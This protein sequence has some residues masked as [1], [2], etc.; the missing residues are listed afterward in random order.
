MT[1]DR[2]AGN[3]MQT[4]FL[5]ALP[6]WLADA[7]P[8]YLPERR[9]FGDKARRIHAV[10][11]S[12]VVPIN[13]VD[14]PSALAFIDVRF[15]SG[16]PSQY[17]L[18][19][20]HTLRLP[21]DSESVISILDDGYLV[22]GLTESSVR[23]RLLST[24]G[25]NV[26][27][28]AKSLLAD[29]DA[30]ATGTLSELQGAESRLLRAEQSNTSILYGSD[31]L[32]KVFRRLQPGINP[33]VELT[34]FLSSR[35]GFDAVPRYLGSIS[36]RTTAGTTSVI[37]CA[38]EFV[39]NVGD[40]WSFVLKKIRDHLLDPGASELLSESA[41]LARQLGIVSARMHLALASDS[42]TPGLA[43]EPIRRSDAE[44]WASDYLGLIDRVVTGLNDQF[45]SFDPETRELATLFL[46]GAPGLQ[47]R[48]DGFYGLIG[49]SKTRVHG[50]YHLGQTLRTLDGSF[51][52][53]DFEG[54]PQRS[55]EERCRKTSPLKDIAGMLR[56]FSYARGTATAWLD[57]ST[58]LLPSDLIAWEREVRSA[59]LAGYVA[60]AR[61]GKESFLPLSSEDFENALA[62]WELDKAAYEVIYEINN[63]PDWLWI[64]LSGMLKQSEPAS[65]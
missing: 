55:I 52:V 4:D 58:S 12:E 1:S 24:I 18:L 22:D 43:P 53:I 14:K 42:W 25:G 45:D 49:K 46:A 60:T 28:G 38:Q 5:S 11:V 57:D 21:A 6:G 50:D 47:K 9:W 44:L 26:A 63:R 16:D 35:A 34:K 23:A 20:S 15:E 61:A 7:L 56:S 59:F 36:H 3:L 8:A 2:V 27:V 37:A 48:E 30:A 64:P 33:D 39:P 10:E 65:S 32:I 41:A 31:V 13:E 19:V 54:E 62:V 51:V 29:H 40:G 17:A